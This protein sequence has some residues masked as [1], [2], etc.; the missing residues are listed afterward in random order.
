METILLVDDED[1][2]REIFG[3]ILQR[4]GYRVLPASSGD[5]AMAVLRD[6]EMA[7]DGV[8]LD[9]VMPGLNGQQLLQQI[10]AARPALPVVLMSGIDQESL[11]GG[12]TP[13]NFQYRFLKKPCR[14]DVLLHVVADAIS[15]V[16]AL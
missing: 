5:Q 11:P 13:A 2:V 12:L 10:H 7:V 4:G 1:A 3:I 9:V 15:G 8:V 6:K 14:Q 16:H